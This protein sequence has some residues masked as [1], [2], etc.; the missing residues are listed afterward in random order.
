LRLALADYRRGRLEREDIKEIDATLADALSLCYSE[1]NNTSEEEPPRTAFVPVQ[2]PVDQIAAR[3]LACSADQSGRV[4]SAAVET[5]SS[6][7][8]LAAIQTDARFAEVDTV[9]LCTVNAMTE[10]QL[11][12]SIRRARR[13]LTHVRLIFFDGSG[14]ATPRAGAADDAVVVSSVNELVAM[15]PSLGDQRNDLAR[16]RQVA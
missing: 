7:L 6:T 16:N 2:G 11:M 3:Y 9:V 4:A 8:G 10:R 15:L 5:T 12:F 1:G 13:S 14:Q